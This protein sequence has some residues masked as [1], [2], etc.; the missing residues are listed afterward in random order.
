MKKCIIVLILFLASF[1]SLMSQVLWSY[2]T[3]SAWLTGTNWTGGSVPGTTAIAQFGAN[4]T[5]GSTGVGINM[6][7]STNNGTS[8]QAIGAIEINSSRGANLIIGNSSTSANGILTVNGA[9]VN[10]ISDVVIRNNSTYLLTIQNTQGTGNKTMGVALGN[11]SN[12]QIVIDGTGGVTVSSIISGVSRKLTKL[13]SGSGVLNLT[14]ANT[15]SGLTTV[16]NGT[17]QFNRVGGTTIP[18]TNNVAITGGTLRIST[19]Q[20]INDLSLSSGTLTVDAGVTLTIN[21][22][23]T[24]SGGTITNSGTIAYGSTSTLVYSQGSSRTTSLEWPSSNPPANVTIESTGTN[25]TLAANRTI[26]GT[27]TVKTGAILNMDSYTISGT[28]DF[29]VQPGA[30]LITAHTDGINGSNTTSGGIS[31]FDEDASYTFNSPSAQVTGTMLPATVNNLTIDN[32]SGV[33]LSNPAVTV[34]GTLTIN[35]GKKFEIGPGKQVTAATIANNGGNAGLLIKSD[36]SGTGSLINDNAGVPATVERYVAAADWGDAGSGWHMLSSPVVTQEISGSWTPSGTGNDYD[37]YAWNESATSLNWLNQ[38]ESGNNITSFFPGKGYFVAYQSASTPDFQGNL[39]AEAAVI[40]GLTRTAGNAY[41]GFNLVGN[42]FP[43]AIDWAVVTKD[44]VS[45][46]AQVWNSTAGSY[47][48]LNNSGAIP[49]M[50]GF[51]VYVLT[52][53][54][55][56]ITIPTAAKVHSSAPWYKSSKPGQI[57]LLARDLDHGTAQPSVICFSE[58]GKTGFDPAEDCP[59]MAG[60]APQFYTNGGNQWL[61]VNTLPN[62]TN[63]TTVPLWFTKNKSTNFKIS[64]E[65]SVEAQVFLT[66]KKM[67]Q[68]VNLSQQGEYQFASQPGDDPQR[69]ML[70]FASVGVGENPVVPQVTIFCHGNKV[71]IRSLDN[72]PLNGEARVYNMLGQLVNENKINNLSIQEI[73][74]NTPTG[75]YIVRM[76]TQGQ[77][78]TRKI[79]IQSAGF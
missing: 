51:F 2:A 18:T 19:A 1:S 46:F 73:P 66:D 16:S 10:S 78:I 3:G 40:S 48:A 14:G 44:N 29:D 27:M 6:N 59:F 7:G 26:S 45:N 37:F 79:F 52:D 70:H 20:T 69:F 55:G 30:T 35:N 68:T 50:N 53:A 71:M 77:V 75:Y 65:E 24:I 43:C 17:I 25:I 21:G 28:G 61:A 8:N 62:V 42:P 63:E 58:S 4:P 32:S 49:A 60:F 67:N 39:N 11:A 41:A 5:S 33:T 12:N 9:T 31:L 54:G 74:V 38:K 47:T 56:S 76:V 22:T 15:Y 64:L 34:S 36:A 23:F 13:G 57:R 72:Q